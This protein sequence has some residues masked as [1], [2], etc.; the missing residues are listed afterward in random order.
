MVDDSIRIP[1]KT[2][3]LKK[4][5]KCILDFSESAGFDRDCQAE[6]EMALD[7]VTANIITHAYSNMQRKEDIIEIGANHLKNGLEII[8]KDHGR[9]FN[10]KERPLPDISNYFQNNIPHGLGIFAVKKFMDDVD[11]EYRDGANITILRKYLK[12]KGNN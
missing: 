12:P 9:P 3:S 2:A 10:L 1:A 8:I 5:R 7:E 11:Y 6:I 4:A